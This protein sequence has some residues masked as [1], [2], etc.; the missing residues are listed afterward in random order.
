MNQL[1]KAY[2][3]VAAVGHTDGVSGLRGNIGDPG[4]RDRNAAIH[5]GDN[6]PVIS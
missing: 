1:L 2:L 4:I 5:R 6:F 3:G